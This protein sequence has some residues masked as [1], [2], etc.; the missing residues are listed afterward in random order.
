ML[1]HNLAQM[2]VRTGSKM[3][4]LGFYLQPLGPVPVRACT[5]PALGLQHSFA[6]TVPLH[7]AAC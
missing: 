7:C 6:F 3:T 5:A 2:Q 4:T 1:I